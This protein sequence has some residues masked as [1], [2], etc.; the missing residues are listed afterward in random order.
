MHQRPI[1]AVRN[2]Q[3]GLE[4]VSREGEG[5]VRGCRCSGTSK[6]PRPATQPG[7]HWG[8][9]SQ[10]T[11]EEKPAHSAACRQIHPAVS[12]I[13]VRCCSHCF[14]LH[15]LAPSCRMGDFRLYCFNKRKGKKWA[16]SNRMTT[17]A[18]SASVLEGTNHWRLP[19]NPW[20]ALALSSSQ[21]AS[22]AADLFKNNRLVWPLTSFMS[23]TSLN[24]N[25]GNRNLW[26]QTRFNMKWAPV[27]NPTQ[28]PDPAVVPSACSWATF[29][30]FGSHLF[31][32]GKWTTLSP[33]AHLC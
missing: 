29:R 18:W 13:A 14:G 24:T 7:A 19:S 5:S 26:I 16:E 17:W 6:E 28:R 22:P 15:L 31:Q 8:S 20:R 32:E 2:P 3:E 10:L 11:R 33:E 27:W 4:S 23:M 12:L 25:R 21:L 9:V 30:Y 1:K